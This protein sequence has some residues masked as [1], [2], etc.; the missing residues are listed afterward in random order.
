MRCE[1]VAMFKGIA[2][3]IFVSFVVTAC[4][5]KSLPPILDQ[6]VV[7]E[8]QK[9]QQELVIKDYTERL[10]RVDRVGYKLRASNL[11]LCGDAVGYSIGMTVMSKSDVYR[12]Y[13]EAAAYFLGLDD[14]VR[15]I[16]V[17]KGG[18]ADFAGVKPG[19][20]VLKVNGRTCSDALHVEFAERTGT[21]VALVLERAGVQIQTAPYPTQICGVSIKIL[22]RPEVN[23]MATGDTIFVFSGLVKFCKTD[24][25]LAV[26]MGHE[27]AHCSMEHMKAKRGNS[28]L[29]S[30][31]IDAPIAAL[32]G[33]NPQIGSNIGAGINSQGFESEADY[34]GMY[35]VARAGYDI[36]NAADIWRRMAVQNPGAVT[37]ASSHP[38]TASRFVGLEAARDEINAKKAA[39]KVLEPNMQA[40]K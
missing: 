36:Q 15:V 40:G 19:D 10:D 7:N 25:E 37:H 20:I 9:R 24:D 4:G 31:L 32:T 28:I 29:M 18:P 3:L 17:V 38:T 5:P 21:S 22:E 27:L 2:F 16:S 13:R 14:R 34:V 12:P 11:E 26:I 1:G 39:G 23:A 8:E 33:F 30:L 35:H 6:G